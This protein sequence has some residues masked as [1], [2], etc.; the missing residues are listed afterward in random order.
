MKNKFKPAVIALL[1]FCAI[2]FAGC[3]ASFLV[4][5]SAVT[6]DSSGLAGIVAIFTEH[7]PKAFTF[8]GE[9]L[10]SIIV[11]EMNAM[12]LICLI[13]SIVII[14]SKKS[15]TPKIFL[16]ILSVLIAVPGNVLGPIISKFIEG[17]NTI[18][19]YDML[20]AVLAYV[21]IVC[22][23][24][25]EA[26]VFVTIFIAREYSKVQASLPDKPVEEEK[27][28]EEVATAP[29]QQ[30]LPVEELE[31]LIRRVVKEELAKWDG[32]RNNGPTFNSPL[33]IQ[34]LNGV[35]PAAEPVKEEP[36]EEPQ[37]AP[38]PVVAEPVKEEPQPAPTPVAEPVVEE[39]VKNPI[40]RIPFQERMV[41]ADKEMKEDYNEIKNELLSYGVKSRVSSS[42][43]TFRLHR[44]T[45]VKIT[46]AGKSLKL[47]FALNP[48]DYKDSTIPV[49]DASDKEIYQEIPLVFKVKSQLSMKRCKQ[50]IADVMHP[51]GLVKGEVGNDD[52]VKEIRA[53]LKAKKK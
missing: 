38:A 42:G 49:Q 36:K 3:V 37:P 47:Y 13:L 33:V 16:I 2:F 21:A 48:A 35:S 30:T 25:F 45:F 7:L 32:P 8:Q 14:K 44:K 1:V 29:T 5:F 39:K 18:F 40:I 9:I 17:A 24:L 53:E 27:P 23:I 26:L 46:I 6:N 12:A 4:S 52:W 31:D 10:D 50:L 28:V 41:A 15:L 22:G 19:D 20:N 34:Y 11:I 51:D 43:D